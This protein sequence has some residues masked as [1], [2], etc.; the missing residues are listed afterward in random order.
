MPSQSLSI[1]STVPL[2]EDEW[3]LALVPH[4][5][6]GFARFRVCIQRLL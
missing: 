1:E 4:R 3:S 2:A 5:L 6:G